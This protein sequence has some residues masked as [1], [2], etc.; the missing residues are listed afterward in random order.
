MAKKKKAVGS[1]LLKAVLVVL[2][3][4]GLAVGGLIGA[5]RYGLFG[6]LPTSAELLA[7]R[8]EEAT[9]IL[10]QNGAVIGKV[11]AQ[12]RTNIRYRDLPKHLV[13]ALVATED[14]R[15][16]AHSGVDAWSYVR[17]FVRT[18]LG[19]DRAG[20]GGSTISQQIIKNLYGRDRHGMLTV[21]VNKIK[22]AI[23]A[24]RLEAVYS[25]EDVIT[26]YLNSVPFGENLY[27]VESA[28]Q[29]FFGKPAQR[30]RVEEGAVLVGMLKANTAYN[31]R[32]NPVDAKQRRDQVLALMA[33]NGYLRPDAADS[34]RKKPLILHYRGLDA[35]DAYGY[36]NAA[37]TAEARRILADLRKKGAWTTDIE[38]DGLRIHTTLDTTL[39]HIAMEA[40]HA[41]L[42]RMQPAL[43]KELR[44]RKQRTAW[45][46]KMAAKGGRAWKRNTRAVRDVFTWS[47][48]PAEPMSYR[49]S[50]WHYQRMLHAAVI[51][52][53]PMSGNVRAWVGGNDHR[54]LPYD[55]VR[56]ERPVASTIK[57]VIYAA[58]LE[59]GIAPCDYLDNADKVYADHDDWHPRNFNDSSGGRVAMW[60]AL[61]HSM[62]LPTVD[63]YFRTDQAKL[64]G[65]FKGLGLPTKDIDKPALALGASDISLA[66]MAVAYGA[67]AARGNR[68]AMR[69]IERITD[70]KGTV[71]YQAK[72]AGRTRA[73]DASTA[74]AITR[75][76]QRAVNEGTGA[77]LRSRHRVKCELAGKTGTSQDYGDAWFIGYT[78]GLVIGTWVGAMDPDIHFSSGAGAGSRLA[79]PIAGQVLADLERMPTLRKRYLL[80]FDW[81]STYDIDLDC[82]PVRDGGFLEDLLAPK[83]RSAGEKDTTT[84]KEPEGFWRK[85]FPKKT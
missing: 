26:L 3:I 39:Q 37:V 43:D 56:A 33:R 77:A 58:G 53:E 36:F 55:L 2:L 10:A 60:Y 85:L 14:Q 65:T 30:L 57:P 59:S 74:A 9:L 71:L 61:A 20:G 32:L 49:D 79:L 72:A 54:A 35:F 34:L 38:K 5:V 4:I 78:P 73:M 6:T 64:A 83:N 40:A 16:F 29:R 41:H 19:G 7:L 82:E 45:E 42:A 11:F 44:A 12:D 18:I 68:T 21:P 70:A 69:Y 80:P 23:V 84:K 25:K 66:R 27:G 67:F 51:M 75:M 62:N 22:E 63:L 46:K 81:L 13:D 48:E 52:V 17:V 76:L 47:D 50:L 28:S 8:N 31:P 1:T 15:F 24:R